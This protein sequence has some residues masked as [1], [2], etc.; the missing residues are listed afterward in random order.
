[1]DIPVALVILLPVKILL[2]MLCPKSEVQQM[3]GLK[4]FIYIYTLMLIH[5]AF[6][7][8]EVGI[9]VI[10]PRMCFIIST[11]KKELQVSNIFFRMLV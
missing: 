5:A 1:M 11:F 6:L 2:D 3:S 10:K 7:E 8:V 4:E 9:N